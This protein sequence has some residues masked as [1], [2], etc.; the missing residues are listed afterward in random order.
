MSG[1]KIG[2]EVKQGKILGELGDL[3]L[4]ESNDP[5]ISNKNQPTPQFLHLHSQS[6]TVVTLV[7]SIK[8]L[9]VR[10]SIHAGMLQIDH[11]YIMS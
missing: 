5:K 6:M 10:A 1:S 4:L 11:I 8:V 2:K 9:I 3:I 7:L